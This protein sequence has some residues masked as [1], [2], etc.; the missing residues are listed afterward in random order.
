MPVRS[1]LLYSFFILF[2]IIF[3]CCPKVKK[4]HYFRTF[5]PVIRLLLH[6]GQTFKT[7]TPLIMR[8]PQ[9]GHL[10]SMAAVTIIAIKQRKPAMIAIKFSFEYSFVIIRAYRQ[11][12][13]AIIRK[14]R[15]ILLPLSKD[16]T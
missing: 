15:T 9:C 1:F 3:F 6:F 2:Y 12:R 4:Y 7:S 14:I 11:S 16:D 13:I 8:F 10:Q 5:S